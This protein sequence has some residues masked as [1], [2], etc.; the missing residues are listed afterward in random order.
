M[1]SS[2]QRARSELK[3]RLKEMYL[4]GSGLS[5][6]LLGVDIAKSTAL[7]KKM[8][9]G[10]GTAEGARKAREAKARKKKLQGFLDIPVPTEAPPMPTKPKRGRPKKAPKKAPAPKKKRG[11]AKGSINPNLKLFNDC[12]RKYRAQNPTV[13]YRKAQ[14]IVK[15]QIDYKRRRCNTKKVV[16]G[17][18]ISGGVLDDYGGVLDDYGGVLDDYGGALSEYLHDGQY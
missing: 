14:Q 11:M 1:S 5:G 6:G 8:Q 7:M 2:D 18:G 9:G 15:K 10:R 16:K 4:K 13:P 12:L 17:S 3:A